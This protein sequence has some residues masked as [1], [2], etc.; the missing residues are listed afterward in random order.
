MWMER[1]G[2]VLT[3]S[4]RRV[5]E[6]ENDQSW[7]VFRASGDEVARAELISRYL[8]LVTR[9]VNGLPSSLARYWCIDDLASFGSLGLIDAIDRHRRHDPASAFEPYAIARIRGAIFD[10]LRALDWLPRASRDQVKEYLRVED[11]LRSEE[12][13]SPS[14]TEVLAAMGISE[15]PKAG[16]TVTAL[17]RSRLESLQAPIGEGSTSR[18][19]QVVSSENPEAVVLEEI[20]RAELMGAIDRL[21]ER[22]RKVILFRYLSKFTQHEVATELKVSDSRVATLERSALNGLR[23]MLADGRAA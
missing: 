11:A 12:A 13:H 2:D 22:Q 16:E 17:S 7:E 6:S 14:R 4:V 8:N 10:E 15:G 19:D 18:V 21:S 9:V 1:R 23:H 3:K 20:A 5:G